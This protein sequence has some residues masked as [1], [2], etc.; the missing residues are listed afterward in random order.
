MQH[1]ANILAGAKDKYLFSERARPAWERLAAPLQD[2]SPGGAFHLALNLRGKSVF[3]RPS[4][5]FVHR[6]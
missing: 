6:H 2:A 1:H 3:K 4:L 5:A